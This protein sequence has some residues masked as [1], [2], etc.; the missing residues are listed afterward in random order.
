LV[1]L[2]LAGRTVTATRARAVVA[3]ARQ[4][5][6]TLLVARG[7]WQGATMR[8]DA[9]VNGYETT[10]GSVPGSGRISRVRLS[11]RAHGRSARSRVG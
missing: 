8:L 7:D 11:I 3:R 10:A 9:R 5:G 6:C 4:K 1:V 2:G